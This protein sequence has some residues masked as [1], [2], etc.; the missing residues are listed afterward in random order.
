MENLTTSHPHKPWEKVKIKTCPSCSSVFITKKEC[1]S[2]GVQFWK[3]NLGEPFGLKSF[4]SFSEIYTNS[5]NSFQKMGWSRKSRKTE[6]F[7]KYQRNLNQRF[8]HLAAYFFDSMDIDKD[9]R[10][11]FLFEAKDI[12]REMVF[13]GMSTKKAWDILEDSEN[14]PLAKVLISFLDSEESKKVSYTNVEKLQKYNLGGVFPITLLG[15]YLLLYG[16][17]LTASIL[18]FKYWSIS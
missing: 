14:N 13:E 8:D 5:L 18:Y 6:S 9:R 15:K 11:L 7:R 10:R 4:Y 2:C 17:I 1:E 3:D 12:L 16:V